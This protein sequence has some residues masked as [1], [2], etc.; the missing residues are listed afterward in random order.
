MA[1]KSI[2]NATP[3]TRTARRANSGKESKRKGARSAA[4]CLVELYS[5]T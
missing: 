5:F 1:G 2:F 4:A 3:S